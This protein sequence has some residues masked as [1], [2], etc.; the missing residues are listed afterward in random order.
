MSNPRRFTQNRWLRDSTAQL[1]PYVPFAAEDAA[2]G[3]LIR[4]AQCLILIFELTGD[5]EVV[6]E[7]IVFVS[8][9]SLRN[10]YL[11]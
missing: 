6:S 4:E 1:L 9:G 2:L 11:I 5:F 8:M 10:W 3:E 7:P